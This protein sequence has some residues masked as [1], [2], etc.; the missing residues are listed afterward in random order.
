MSAIFD[1]C[2]LRITI[3]LC[4]VPVRV[5]VPKC[6][7]DTT[8]NAGSRDQSLSIPPQSAT[9]LFLSTIAGKQS[10]KEA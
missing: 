9:Q 5:L 7:A 1:T 2:D 3:Q 8:K 4:I 10:V 6:K